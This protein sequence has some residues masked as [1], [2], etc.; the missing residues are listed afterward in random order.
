MAKSLDSVRAGGI[1][2]MV[3]SRFFLDSGTSEHREY[4]ADRAHFLGAIRLP[5]N[6][7]KQ[8]ALTT[9]TTD[10]VFFQKAHPWKK[11][12]VAG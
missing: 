5:E 3:V 11:P 9:V 2:A 6:A 4:I 12:N 7:F 8:N 1:T 10:I